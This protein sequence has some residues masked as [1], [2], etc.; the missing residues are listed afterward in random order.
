MPNAIAFGIAALSLEWYPH[1]WPGNCRALLSTR[2][3]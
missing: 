2:Q 1:E 3:D